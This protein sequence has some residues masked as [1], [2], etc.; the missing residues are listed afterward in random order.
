[1]KR[2]FSLLAKEEGMIVF[3]APCEFMDLGIEYHKE[4][5]RHYVS[6]VGRICHHRVAL[7]KTEGKKKN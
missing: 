1:M 3:A 6:P 5:T 4:T 2:T 7:P